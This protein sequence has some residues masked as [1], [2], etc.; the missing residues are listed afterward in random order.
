MQFLLRSASGG[1]QIRWGRSIL[2]TVKAHLTVS[3]MPN[4]SYLSTTQLKALGDEKALLEPVLERLT[5]AYAPYRDF[6][7]NGFLEI[8][9]LERVADYL[10]DA[11]QIEANSTLSGSKDEVARLIDG[12]LKAIQ[13]GLV[14]SRVLRAGR[15]ATIGLA[16]GAATLLR[17]LPAPKFPTVAAIADRL[18]QAGGLLKG[19]LDRETNEIE[20]R[21]PALRASVRGAVNDLHEALTQM[22]GRLRTHFSDVFIDSLY[23]EL[24][25][26]G[27]RVADVPE[28]DTA[29]P[30][31]EGV[32]PSDAPTA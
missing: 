28:D 9:A 2:S 3:A 18:D 7:D 4:V 25:D 17:I 15:L 16:T 13:G 29:E 32:A 24:K 26:R 14:L 10:C 31:P 22:N 5:N 11:G 21:R 12:G 27:S 1:Q 23:P 20:S 30:G 6:L 19:F 8:R